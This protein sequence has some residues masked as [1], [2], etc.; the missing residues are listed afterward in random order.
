MLDREVFQAGLRQ[1]ELVIKKNLTQE[2]M[3]GM[4]E[5]FHEESDADFTAAVKNFSTVPNP[6]AVNMV[7][8]IRAYIIGAKGARKG[9]T[10]WKAE[11]PVTAKDIFTR[12]TFLAMKLNKEIPGFDFDYYVKKLNEIWMEKDGTNLINAL[13][14]QY[15]ELRSALNT[16]P[17][18]DLRP[19]SW[20]KWGLST[21]NVKDENITKT[22]IESHNFVAKYF[23]ENPH[24]GEAYLK[25]DK[26]AMVAEYDRI[27]EIKAK[28]EK[29][30]AKN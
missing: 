30:D 14:F 20:V 11:Y 2:N 3:D 19:D 15:D 26:Y 25:M 22:V 27:Q 18:N 29:K 28:Q 5:K 4:W 7:E 24:K 9:N 6:W 17:H 23:D 10:Q 16:N 8:N 21:N 1:I 12:I 13:K